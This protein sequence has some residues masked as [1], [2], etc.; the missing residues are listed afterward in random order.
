[1]F[2]HILIPT[3]GSRLAAKGAASGLRLAKALGARVTCLYVAPPYTPAVYGE[4]AIYYAAPSPLDHKRAVAKQAQKV[5]SAVQDKARAAG[6]RCAAE[7]IADAQPWKA[8]L[9]IARARKCD[10]IAM[11]THGRSGLGG[12]ILGSETTKVLAN[13][14]VPVLVVR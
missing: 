13:S 6:V 1:M 14:K 10:A 8:I 7:H 4:A 11:A 5:L 9:K 2:K 12:L 3:D